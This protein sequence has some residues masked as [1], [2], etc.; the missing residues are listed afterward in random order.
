MPATIFKDRRA[1]QIENDYLR[2]TVLQEGG[3]IAEIFDKLTGVSPLWIPPW[4]SIEPSSYDTCKHPE[5][6]AGSEVKLLAGIMGHNLCLDI[7]GGPSAEEARA[8]L[9]AHGEGSIAA[10]EITESHGALALRVSFPLAQLHF[11]R[12]I[13]LR[14]RSLGIRE[15]VENLAAWDRPI[16]WTQHVTLGPPFLEK[17]RTQFRAC[18]TRSKVYETDFGANMFL[19]AGAEFNWPMAPLSSGGVVDLRMMSNAPSSSEYTAHLADPRRQHVFFVAFAPAFQLAFGY[20][21]KRAEFPWLGMWQENCSR[22]HSPWNSS[23]VAL[24]LE[25]GVSPIPESR[26]EMVDRGRMFDVPT[27]RW[28]PAKGR[29][30]AEYWVI[31]QNADHIPESIDWPLARHL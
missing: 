25:F 11:E 17:G 5:F 6:G 9:T 3:H 19:E 23:T 7:F 12:T 10:Y 21:W 14:E 1:V 29:L 2:V 13:E 15:F 24:G 26:R 27:Y 31:A 4:P 18:V 30:E 20:I 28:L 22:K 16:G 8:G